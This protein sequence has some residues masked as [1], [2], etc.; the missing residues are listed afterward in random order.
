METRQSRRGGRRKARGGGCEARKPFPDWRGQIAV[1]CA[2]GP[3]QNREDIER[4]KGKARIVCINETWRLAPW[5]DGLY[6]CD[7]RWWKLRGPKADEFA[8]IRWQGHIGNREGL[9]AGT[10]WGGVLAGHNQMI[11]DGRRIGA[12]GNSGFQA[13]NLVARTGVRRVILLG[14][15][16]GHAG[17]SHWH[18]EHGAGLSNPA[19]SFLGRCAQILDRSAQDL[20]FRKVEVVNASRESR[21][22]RFRRVS[23]DEALE[24]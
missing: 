6:A 19:S 22:Q 20:A 15:D 24:D 2:S 1:I 7:H 3:S 11:W 5:A 16:M 21:L 10:I 9:W 18:G 23:I 8:G 17:R 4:C 13:L 14:Y 12:G